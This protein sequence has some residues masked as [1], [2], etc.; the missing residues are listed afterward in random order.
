[1]KRHPVDLYFRHF[2]FLCL[3]FLEYLSDTRAM[4]A[5]C[6]AEGLRVS[7]EAHASFEVPYLFFFVP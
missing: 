3:K 2:A 7:A 5:G 1:M 4:G 6:K